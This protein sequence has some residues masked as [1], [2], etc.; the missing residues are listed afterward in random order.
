MSKK[1]VE[2]ITEKIEID[3]DNDLYGFTFWFMTTQNPDPQQSYSYFKKCIAIYF[4][5]IILVTMY[6][7]DVKPF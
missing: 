6:V 1:L 5:Q 3:F 7:I 4:L 2:E